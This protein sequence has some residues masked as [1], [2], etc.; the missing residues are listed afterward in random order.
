[1][2]Y[3]YILYDTKERIAHVTLNRPE[4]LNAMNW[5]MRKEIVNA[6]KTA[7]RDD[8]VRVIII[9]G[10]GRAFS[11]GFDLTPAAQKVDDTPPDGIYVSPNLDRWHTRD[12]EIV[13][14]L[15]TAW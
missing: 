11:A 1:M 5:L 12:R 7:E 8:N 3:K 14:D 15:R 2:A 13:E 6:L 9:K 4:K 10:A